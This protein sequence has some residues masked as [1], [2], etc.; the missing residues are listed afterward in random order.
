MKKI[1]KG[2]MRPFTAQE[3]VI[4]SLK[5]VTPGFRPD[6]STWVRDIAI[7]SV[8]WSPSEE[9]SH[10]HSSGTCLMHFRRTADGMI[11]PAKRMRFIIECS[12]C[13]DEM[14]LPD[15]IVTK[16]EFAEM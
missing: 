8:H 16:S 1:E 14:G 6:C 10:L 7:E 12:D 9:N 5:K 15:V 3:R 11:L 2:K 13:K 4:L